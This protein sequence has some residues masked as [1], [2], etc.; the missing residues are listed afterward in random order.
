MESAIGCVIGVGL[1]IVDVVTEIEIVGV[2]VASDDAVK[3]TDDDGV[4]IDV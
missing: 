1:E 4:V 3:V 2:V